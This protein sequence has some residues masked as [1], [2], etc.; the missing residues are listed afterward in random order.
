MASARTP[1]LPSGPGHF[2]TNAFTDS[3]SPPHDPGSPAVR[4]DTPKASTAID[5]STILQIIQAESWDQLR[6]LALAVLGPASHNLG[7]CYG[8]AEGGWG[9]I[10]GLLELLKMLVLEGLYEEAHQSWKWGLVHPMEYVEAQLAD[11]LMHSQLEAAHREYDALV[12]QLALV[13]KNPGQFFSGIWNSEV[14]AYAAKW[15]RYKWLLAHRTLANEFEAGRIEGQ[16]LLEVILL[17]ATVVDGVGLALKGAKALGEIPELV[18]LAKGVRSVEEAKSILAARRLDELRTGAAGGAESEAAAGT[19]GRAPKSQPQ[20]RAWSY[21][22]RQSG[23]IEPGAVPA[24]P[25]LDN[26]M[27][28]SQLRTAPP[29]PD[30]WPPISDR[31]AATFGADPQPV[32]LTPGTKLYRVI[33]SDDSAS[34]AFWSTSPP[35]ATEGEWRSASAVKDAWNGDGGYVE[36]TVGSDGLKAWSGPA[37]PQQAAVDG[38]TLP[39]GGQQ[40][41][42]P[43]GTLAKDG[44]AMPTPWNLNG[45]R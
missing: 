13:V 8:L 23:R 4:Y 40:V 34:G 24:N 26:A 22:A 15:D 18:R 17:L 19:S 3:P 38:Y 36:S 30:G 35:P 42:V 39:G 37:A 2:R 10:H 27:L 41:W 33:G 11:R 7:I 43:P 45:G 28:Q 16:V 1:A 32:N 9:I 12:T 25:D 44:P 29:T 31:T 21:Q 14:K 6:W 5:S 20:P